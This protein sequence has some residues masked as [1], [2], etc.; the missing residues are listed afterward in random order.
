MPWS[1]RNLTRSL[2][3]ERARR[4]GIQRTRPF[5]L[6]PR[7]G[8]TP[9]TLLRMRRPHAATLTTPQTEPNTLG[10]NR[11]TSTG[12]IN[13]ALEKFAKS[14]PSTSV[15]RPPPKVP[16][17]K[18]EE[19]TLE[20]L[21]RLFLGAAR[22]Q[23]AKEID[24]VLVTISDSP[25]DHILAKVKEYVVEINFKNRTVLHDCQDWRKNVASKNMCKHL[26]KFLLTLDE[27]R[28]TNFLREVLVNKDKWTFTAPTTQN[29]L[30]VSAR[31]FSASSRF[32]G[33]A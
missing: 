20:Q 31:T 18:A 16:S 11:P 21:L 32:R 8:G 28:A 6:T 2:S 5:T 29:H 23:R 24:D 10:T 15:R 26:G 9:Y 17:R 33:R 27:K 22:L 12:G 13:Q 3:E 1:V 4:R 30:L 14:G 25:S 19:L 7:T